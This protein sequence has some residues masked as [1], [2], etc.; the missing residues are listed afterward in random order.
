MKKEISPMPRYF[1]YAFQV[2][3]LI[4]I[5]LFSSLASGE[6][7][8]PQKHYLDNGLEVILV[9]MH[10]SPIIIQQLFYD[11][12]SRNEPVG[13]TGISHVVEHMMFKGTKKFPT[14]KISRL[15]KRN[16]GVFNAYTS[17]DM[18]VY[19]EQMPRNKI[20][21]ALEIES[22]RMMNSILDPAEFE[23]EVNV[24]KEERRL[25]VENNPRRIFDEELQ[26]TFYMSHPYHWPIIGWMND[27][28]AITRQDAYAYYKTY[29]T[30]NNA[31]LVLVGDFDNQEML[32]KV[33]KYFG[34]IPRGP[35]VPEMKVIEP[36]IRTHKTVSKSSPSVINPTYLAWFQG[37]HFASSDYPALSLAS[38]I[39][40]RGRTSRLYPRLVKS[41]LC[42]MAKFSVSRY[43]DMGPLVF[44]AELYPETSLDTVKAIF[45]DEIDRM[46]EEPVSV[47]ELRKIK[48]S[49]QVSEA[50]DNM[51]VSEVASRIGNYELQAGDFRYYQK[52]RQDIDKVTPDDILRVMNTYLDF[53]FYLEG[54]LL[55]GDSLLEKL[56]AETASDLPDD[57]HKIADESTDDEQVEFDP[58]NFIRPNPIAP[59]LSEFQLN[60]GIEV[61]FYEDHSFPI[62]ELAGIIDIGNA[63]IPAGKK[64]VEQFTAG[65]IGQGS[66][67]YP[68]ET[69]IDTL[70][71]LSTSV[72][73]SGGEENVIFTWGTIKENFEAVMDIGS[74]LLQNPVF[75]E[76]ELEQMRKQRIAVLKEANKKTGWNT[77]RYIVE[78]IFRDHPYFRSLTVEALEGITL[79]EIQ[80]FY[81]IHYQPSLT[82]LVVLGDIT[83]TDLQDLLNHYLGNWK[84]GTSFTPPPFPAMQPLTGMEIKV[85][86][87][88]EDKQLEV[89]IAHEAPSLHDPDYEKLEIANHILGGSSLT[90]RLGLNIRDQQG[91]TYGISSK[92]KGRVEGGWWYLE[93]K[94]APENVAR[95]LVSAIFEIDRMRREEVTVTE[96]NDAKRYYMGI[97]PMVVEDPISIFRL[98]ID[99]VKTGKSLNDFDTYPERL[100]RVNRK[101]VLEV[102]KKYFHPERS[103]ITVG[104]PITPQELKTA[105]MEEMSRTRYQ[106]PIDLTTV[107]I[108][109]IE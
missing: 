50:Y 87:N 99:N 1:H 58:D 25:R 32:K 78:K 56:L 53:N 27:L 74:D 18:T 31:T 95:L 83:Q 75:P 16:S 44:M 70:A 11:V 67:K 54:T 90:S 42:R 86:T 12:G 92:L 60:N 65:L 45:H 10:K 21:I 72:N 30:P 91:L 52:L 68:Y 80:D 5:L 62:V 82:R 100:I 33:K 76:E 39:L 9:E 8:T 84:T 94:T 15:I 37:V 49:Y 69:L 36:Q 26:A 43:R 66:K 40:S 88:P 46:K 96:L 2:K 105:V 77:S 23:R 34:K 19:Y 55:P 108:G 103:I 28:D 81:N 14:G 63:N 38:S 109:S 29:Y 6:T 4:I 102:S 104:G 98:L 101:D 97:L 73:F 41:K 13:K 61:I 22:D 35:K 79:E 3:L 107:E 89:R 59:A 20:D 57:E 17:N 47:R 48:N 51:K 85:Y 7:I 93:S 106:I 71:M 64:G 24:I